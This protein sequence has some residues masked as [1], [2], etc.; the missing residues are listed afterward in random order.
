MS[1][2]FLSCNYYHSVFCPG[3]LS[4]RSIKCYKMCL[5]VKDEELK[6]FV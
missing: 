6:C 3:K 4:I 5:N 1:D 2:F